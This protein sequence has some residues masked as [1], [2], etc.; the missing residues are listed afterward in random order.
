MKK[1]II[2]L[3]GI[4]MSLL[5]TAIIVSSVK[6]SQVDTLFEKYRNSGMQYS[7][8]E[9]IYYRCN[10]NLYDTETYILERLDK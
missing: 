2:I 1:A 4:I 7:Q 6:K 3:V 5:A 8:I 9:I 10:C